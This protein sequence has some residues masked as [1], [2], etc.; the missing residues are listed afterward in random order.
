MVDISEL[1]WFINQLITGGAPHCRG[2]TTLELM[3][4]NCEF[5]TYQLRMYGREIEAEMHIGDSSGC[6]F[7]Y[8]K[9]SA[10]NHT[11]GWLIAKGCFFFLFHRFT[12]YI[13]LKI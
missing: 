4:K 12:Y 9:S 13:V 3:E 8:G 7:K 11:E 5:L 10:K 1:I 2:S 6:Y